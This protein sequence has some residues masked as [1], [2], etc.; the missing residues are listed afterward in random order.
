MHLKVKLA[1]A[2]CPI[3]KWGKVEEAKGPES[4]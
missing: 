3:G 2:E 4:E 1:P